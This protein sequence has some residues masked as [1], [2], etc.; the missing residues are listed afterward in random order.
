MAVRLRGRTEHSYRPDFVQALRRQLP[1]EFEVLHE[2]YVESVKGGKVPDLV[3]IR[4]DKVLR[5][6]GEIVVGKSGIVA[7]IETKRSES[8]AYEGLA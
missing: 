1:C 4:K 6:D 3:V 5:Q 8:Q 2:A 7:V